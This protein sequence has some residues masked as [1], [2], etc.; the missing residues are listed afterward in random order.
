MPGDATLPEVMRQARVDTARAVVVAT[1]NELAN[2]EMKFHKTGSSHEQIYRHI[3]ANLDDAHLKKDPGALE[4]LKK[5]GH[6]A[7]MTKAA[8]YLLTFDDFNKFLSGFNAFNSHIPLTNT[9][10]SAPTNVAA[11]A[12]GR[13]HSLTIT[14][15]P[16]TSTMQPPEA[17]LGRQPSGASVSPSAV[18]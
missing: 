2:V 14:W 17:L 12:D 8:S 7:A 16:V 15:L 9:L 6:V 18:T 5:K 13:S 4:H 3:L 1:N 10:L 11:A